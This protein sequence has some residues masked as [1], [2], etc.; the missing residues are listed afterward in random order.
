M[1]AMRLVPIGLAVVVAAGLGFGVGLHIFPASVYTVMGPAAL[2]AFGIA[3]VMPGTTTSA[4]AKFATIAGAASALTGFLQVG[5]G[6][7]GS[8]I[9]AL[10]FR[11]PFL[12]LTVVM[13][14]MAALAALVHVGLAPRR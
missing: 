9:A 6:L 5:G 14:G 13:P 4:L 7:A 10:V 12:A 2:W 3:L 8:A 11:D 1:D